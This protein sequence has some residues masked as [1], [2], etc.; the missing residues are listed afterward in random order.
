MIYCPRTQL[1]LLLL[2]QTIQ[3]EDL[4]SHSKTEPNDSSRPHTSSDVSFLLNSHNTLH[5]ISTAPA[6][7][8]PPPAYTASDA[9]AETFRLQGPLIYAT[10]PTG[11]TPRY[12]LQQDFT[13]WGRP[14]RLHIRRLGAFESRA[15]LS[16]ASNQITRFDESTAMFVTDGVEMKSPSRETAA[17]GKIVLESGMGI[18]GKWWK[19]YRVTK[20]P[21]RDSLNPKNQARLQKYGYHAADEWDKRL[22]FVVRKGGTWVDNE[23]KRVGAE[24]TES[25]SPG[26]VF[27]VEGE[28]EE[29]RRDLLVACWLMKLWVV[30]GVR[31]EGDRTV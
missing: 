27:T 6:T 21:W 30:K 14:N 9:L 22:L 20:S 25:K 18:T 17:R 19:I 11:H 8:Q 7:F 26:E 16:R 31:W 29:K 13:F 2:P 23:G 5:Q 15:L 10:A 28:V 1:A 12:H 4:L 24:L 3:H